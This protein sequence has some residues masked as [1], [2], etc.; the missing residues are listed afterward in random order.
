MPVLAAATTCSRNEALW[1][2]E[3]A[4]VLGDAADF[5]PAARASLREV[6]TSLLADPTM[7]PVSRRDAWTML[8]AISRPALEVV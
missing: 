5:E 8:E 3:V 4:R 1:A 2:E 6:L 7:D